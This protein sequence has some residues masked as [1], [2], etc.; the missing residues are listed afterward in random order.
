M[1]ISTYLKTGIA[2]IALLMITLMAHAQIAYGGDPATAEH[3]LNNYDAAIYTV[4]LNDHM[5]GIKQDLSGVNKPGEAP[6]AGFAIPTSVNLHNQGQWDVAGSHLHV[7]RV[8]IESPGALATGLNFSAYNLEKGARLFIYDEKMQTVLGAFDHRNNRDNGRFSTAVIPGDQVIIEYQEPWYPG[9]ATKPERG[10]LEIEGVIHITDGGGVAALEDGK[11]FGDAGDCQ[12][13]INCPEGDPWQDEKRGIARMLMREDNSYY[14]CTGSLVNNTAQDGTPYLLSAEHC[15]RGASDYDL[16]FWQFYFNFEHE[17]CENQD[18]PPYNMVYGAD[19]QAEGPLD[20]GS[21]FRLVRLHKTPPAHWQPYFNGW[22]RTN[23]GSSAGAGIH[24]PHGD[25]KKISTYDIQ[26]TS[27]APNVSDQQMADNSAWRVL[28]SETESGHGVTEPGSSGSPIFNEEKKIIGT[29]TGG[30]ATCDDPDAPD[31]YGKV[32]YHW[33]QNDT[34]ESGRL[35]HY[36]DPLE[37]GAE[38]MAGYDPYHTGYP[39][40][41]FIHARLLENQTAE[42][43]WYAPGNAPNKEGWHSYVQ[44]YTH[45]TWADPERATLFDAHELGINY[46]VHLKKISHVFVEHD[47]HT[48]PD[49]Q[50]RFKVY[51]RNGHDLLYESDNL[52][53]THLQEVVY[54]LEDPL[55]LDDFFYVA[56]DP[57]DDSGHPSS[58]MK[59]VNLG[60]GFSFYG[61]AGDWSPHNDAQEGSFAYMTKIFID[62]S[63]DGENQSPHALTSVPGQNNNRKST[64]VSPNTLAKKSLRIINPDEEPDEYRI[65]RNDEHIHTADP[66]DDWTHTDFLSEDGLFRYHAT[67]VYNDQESL[68]SEATYLLKAENCGSPLDQWPYEE[69]FPAGFDDDCWLYYGEE[70]PWSLVTSHETDAGTLTPHAGDAFFVAAGTGNTD[71]DEWLVLPEIDF[72]ELLFPAFRF[73]VSNIFDNEEQQ[74]SLTVMAAHEGEAFEKVWDSRNHPAMGTGEN[75][76]QWLPVTINLDA[77]GNKESVRL[78]F[79]YTGEQDG[80]FAIDMLEILDA[81]TIRHNLAINIDPEN[82]GTAIGQGTYLAGETVL[83]KA[84]PNITYNFEAWL[85]NNVEVSQEKELLYTM[86]DQNSTLTAQFSKSPLQ[87][88]DIHIEDAVTIFPNPASDQLT[89]QFGHSAS[90]VSVSLFNTH[91]QQVMKR[92]INDVMKGTEKSLSV[93]QLAAGIYYIRIESHDWQEVIKFI[94]QE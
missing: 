70:E 94:L 22:D 65:Y 18:M 46:P 19:F 69:M 34:E 10:S 64:E 76:L 49:N 91:G 16:L 6:L 72:S 48:W 8:K 30:A 62:D 54:E 42:V 80:Y 17:G 41:G 88:P 37:T 7:W 56:I 83:L 84:S 33:D 60:E 68:P 9:K 90:S 1:T 82:A 25:A 73:M 14:W 5:R 57:S 77:L 36:L 39:P 15:G 61:T 85:E 50:F 55:I 51:D 93:G 78:A 74:G 75:D 66:E 79:Q 27:A 2:G 67:A 20:G 31:F 81:T 59:L 86:P 89:L 32:W 52:T 35:D 29:L 13:N 4:S 44:E 24:H 45:L 87:L 28:W 58:L 53:A 40:P 26:L 71:H 3:K 43:S 12:V 23:Q 47:E 63:R 21:D 38:T 11:G 92:E